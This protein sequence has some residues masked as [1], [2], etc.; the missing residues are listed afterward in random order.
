MEYLFIKIRSKSID[1]IVKF[2]VVDS[3]DGIEYS[4]QI[5]LDEIEIKYPEDHKNEISIN[6]DYVVVMKYPTPKLSEKISKLTTLADI[7]FETIS[8]CI[9]SVIADDGVIL[10][11]EVSQSEKNTFIDSLPIMTFEQIQKFFDTMPTIEHEVKYKNS[12][13]KEK[14][15]VFRDLEDFF[16]LG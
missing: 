14:K 2:S 7:T 12:L 1:N 11:D 4:L 5:N 9:E 16:T 15:V 13:D 3:E 8:A 10:W 6:D